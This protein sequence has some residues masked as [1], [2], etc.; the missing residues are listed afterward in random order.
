MFYTSLCLLA[1]GA[2]GV[3]GSLAALGADQ[4]DEKD[5]KG[6]KALA[7]YFNLM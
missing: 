5:P 7:S 1:L 3:K 2:G 6:T 4:F